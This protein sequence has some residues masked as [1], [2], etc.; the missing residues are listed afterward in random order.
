MAT[1]MIVP[2]LGFLALTACGGGGGG[3]G[4][5]PTFA[6]LDAEADALLSTLAGSSTSTTLP[7]GSGQF[8]GVIVMTDDQS[9]ITTGTT[10]DGFIGDVFLNA[11]FAGGT[12]TG[13]AGG[14]FAIQV[15]EDTN[16]T[17]PASSVG[18]SLDFAST[19]LGP[20]LGGVVVSVTGTLDVNG[21]GDSIT[22][23]MTGN[24]GDEGGSIANTL[25]LIGSGTDIAVGGGG[26][27]A[28]L[29]AALIAVDD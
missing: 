28:D 27:I 10:A 24:F 4:G 12:M 9:A 23:T 2:A 17:G 5:A 18:G 26:A 1:K 14:F 15:D 22:G 6:Q 21:T 3:G 13:T 25:A 11:D 19:S 20:G 8:E 16:P 29:D 7:G